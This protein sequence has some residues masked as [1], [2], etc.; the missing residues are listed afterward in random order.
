MTKPVASLPDRL[1]VPF[2]D[3]V[4]LRGAL[5]HHSYRYER[6]ADAQA[7]PDTQRLE[8]LGDSVVN[9]VATRLVF[10]HFPDADEGTMTRLRSALIRTENLAAI[11]THY[12]LG[13]YVI[14]AKGEEH[15]G[16]RTRASL[17][18]DVCESVI[19][20][21]YI[22]QGLSAVQDFLA[23][24]FVAHLDQLR[25]SGTPADPRS[26]L[27]EE[28]QRRYGITPRYQTVSSSGPEHQ[29]TFV[30]EATIGAH[31][32]GSGSGHS[33]PAARTAAASAALAFLEA[34]PAFDPTQPVDPTP[35]SS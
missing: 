13:E 26:R 31:C 33:Q 24:H 32:V 28:S 19:A 30:I 23:P 9:L 10:Q 11:A 27:Q 22:D 21:I 7:H 3:L 12:G 29:R 35:A 1:G 18:A 15:A 34:H 25:A 17:L 16:G 4:L 5:M 20:A 14:L 8:F 6:P 2:R